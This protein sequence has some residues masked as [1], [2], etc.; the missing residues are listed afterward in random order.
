M[1]I[2]F[3]LITSSSCDL[4][5][6][7]SLKDG[8]PVS[9][10]VAHMTT[11]RA[12]II[13][14]P[15]LESLHTTL[16]GLASNQAITVGVPAVGDT[17]LTTRAGAEFNPTAVARTNEAFRYLNTPSLYPIDVDTDAGS[18]QTA[19]EVLDALESASPWLRHTVR[20]ARP[21]AS[22]YV[23][24]NGLRGVHVYIAVTRG[25][26][27]PA[28][29]Q[30]MQIDQWTANRGKVIISKSGALLTR[31]L[32]DATVYQ[33][34]R[35]LFEALPVLG[36]GVTRSVPDSEKWL[37]RDAD[38]EGKAPPYR[39]DDGMLDVQKMP[40]LKD[41]DV[42][43]FETAVR[44]AK[45]GKRLEAKRVA[46]DYHRAN[47]LAAGR[48]DGDLLGVL[49]LRA[50]GDKVLPPS[51]PLVFDF[52]GTLQ[53]GT[54]RDA[55]GALDVVM[56]R[57]CAD[58]FEA[59]KPNLTASD[60]RA[61]EVCTMHGRP[62]IWSHK[63]GEFF[64]FGDADAVELSHPLELAA[65]RLCGTIEEWPD[66]ADKKRSSVANLVFAVKLL[67]REAPIALAHDVCR[68][69]MHAEDL[70]PI[71]LWLD[72]VTRMGSS[73]VAPK[74]LT[75]ALE[76]VSR[77]SPVDPWK[78]TILSLPVWDKRPRLDT[79]FSDLFGAPGSEAQTGATQVFFAGI[80]MRQLRPGAPCPVVPV[81][82]GGQGV[83]KSL[84]VA[85][86]C[87]AMGWPAPTPVAFSHDERKMSMAAA[88][89]PVA[90]LAEMSG[91]GKREAEDVKRWVTDTVDAYRTPYGTKEL[92]HPRRF[93]L[94]GTGNKHEMNRDETG[95]RRFM[96]ILCNHS[97][98]LDWAVELPQILAEAKARFCGTFEQYIKL[99]RTVP[100]LVKEHNAQDMRQGRGTVQSDLD[101]LLP[102]ILAKQLGEH[103]T[104]ESSAIRQA[105]DASPS[106][107][108]YDA[109]AVAVWLKTRHWTAATNGR[110]MRTYRPPAD[111]IEANAED[112]TVDNVVQLDPFA[113]R[114]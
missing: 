71:G 28:L 78:D 75:A 24:G 73:V 90:E 86:I 20:V 1:P 107:R 34:S 15:N 8:K 112:S 68:D 105:L 14:A 26:D 97:A 51:W 27:I 60:L 80:V 2:Q 29:A 40:P 57:R 13:S 79:L 16:D 55:L 50:L 18:F 49:A 58:P 19:A 53:Q 32:S 99:I 111:W 35:L 104:V 91:M 5:K 76:I 42:R 6:S 95:N 69:D 47:A 54:V 52:D 23:G 109:R 36:E 96:P 77:A 85:R 4:A 41:I 33:P 67:C 100:D 39:A 22:S 12:E 110:G 37:I 98:P 101:D 38:M 94:I 9:S 3:T 108:R 45:N 87:E 48:E 21:S 59:T 82:I 61:A 66:R 81:L 93:T 92:D 89:S 31:Q 62:G 88:R 113:A 65:E 64:A 25:T 30:R 83:D 72:A 56:G 84:F 106:G 43:R 103:N 44:N 114:K 11:G 63:I 102:P 10:A 70:P 46:L 7:Y 17:P 74:S